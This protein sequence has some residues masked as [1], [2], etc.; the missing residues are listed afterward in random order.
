[1]LANSVTAHY[2]KK[3]LELLSIDHYAHY[4]TI[5]VSVV[6]PITTSLNVCYSRYD[7]IIV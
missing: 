1:M 4:N 5:K 3:N 2:G 7:T 6:T